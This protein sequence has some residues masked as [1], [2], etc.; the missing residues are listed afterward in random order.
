M[1]WL[2]TV[3]IGVTLVTG[4]V[5][6]WVT[7]GWRLEARI[8]YLKES[9]AK[10]YAEALETARNREK[11]LVKQ[12]EQIRRTKDAQIKTIDARLASALNSLRERPQD[13]LLPTDPAPSVGC[14][15]AQLAN[16]DGEFLARYAAD[17]ARLQSA[18]QACVG[19][20]DAARKSVE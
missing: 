16:P 2:K 15:G 20:Y 12:T 10:S 4:F 19:A 14:T 1:P 6:G 3:I 9:Y 11:A 13:R 17:A 5:T 18:Y 8:A 7:N